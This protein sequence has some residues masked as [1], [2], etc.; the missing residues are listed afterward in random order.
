MIIV[1]KKITIL[2]FMLLFIFL[3]VLTFILTAEPNN[4]IVVPE[5][6][7]M[8]ILSDSS[9]NNF[10]V[11]DE[12]SGLIQLEENPP[13]TW[14]FQKYSIGPVV[15]ACGPDA[16][17]IIYCTFWNFA[18]DG[19]IY[20]FD[21][22]SSIV[23]DSASFDNPP[24][25]IVLS[26]DETKLYVAT[27]QWPPPGE[28]YN[29]TFGY[30]YPDTGLILEISIDS[31]SVLRTAIT[32]AFPETIYYA[33]C[34]E[35]KI[36]VSTFESYTVSEESGSELTGN[37][38]GESSPLD[39]IDVST[40]SRMEP[41]IFGQLPRS[42][43]ANI[44]NDWPFEEC[45]MA[46]SFRTPFMAPDNPEYFDGIWIIDAKTNSIVTTINVKNI[47]NNVIG[48]RSIL[49]SS[50]YQNR[51]Y[52]AGGAHD[53]AIS[54]PPMIGHWIYIINPFSGEIIDAISTG[55]E[56]EYP[57]F[58]TELPDGRLLV[59]SGGDRALIIET[60]E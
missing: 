60:S 28:H 23:V 54:P 55:T 3:S 57:I 20:Y 39:I 8:K 48:A 52:V 59:T 9:P 4:L 33:N 34:D 13:G 24:R 17:G 15:D 30:M 14:T 22:D 19:G 5:S 49:V 43:L 32:S 36:I 12:N 44:M 38:Y 35:D 42:S 47:S 40:F 11:V 7:L 1:K 46:I 50:I 10:W 58:L 45:Q 56:F 31:K 6:S 51:V 29:Q 16:D 26:P 41:R 53:P 2:L 21:T 37:A 27:C 25:G 18:N